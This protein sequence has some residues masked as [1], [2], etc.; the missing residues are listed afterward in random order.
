[1]NEV[2]DFLD[3]IPESS[4]KEFFET[5]IE[6]KNIKIERIVSYGQTTPND[7]WYDQNKDEFVFIIEGEATVLYN[8]KSKYHLTKGKSLYIKAHQKHKVIYTANPTIWLAVFIH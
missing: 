6:N 4:K 1:M 7:F 2:Y 5:I 8:N 3:D